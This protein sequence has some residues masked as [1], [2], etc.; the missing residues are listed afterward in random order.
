M[1]S[2]ADFEVCPVS[3][4][5]RMNELLKRSGVQSKMGRN[6]RAAEKHAENRIANAHRLS[7][8]WAR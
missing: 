7:Q 8:N 1:R 5:C 6:T 2:Q 4:Y 3:A